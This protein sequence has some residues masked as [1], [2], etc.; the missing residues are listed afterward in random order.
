MTII[1]WHRF[2]VGRLTQTL[3]KYSVAQIYANYA[4]VYYTS[5][6]CV[7]AYLNPHTCAY[8]RMCMSPCLCIPISFF[9]GGIVGQTKDI[10]FLGMK[11]ASKRNLHVVKTS[12]RSTKLSYFEFSIT[13]QIYRQTTVYVQ[14]CSNVVYSGQ[15]A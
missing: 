10:I 11:K 4:Y 12:C 14:K 5:I 9:M 15:C 13:L 2:T 6:F 8:I 7:Y 1:L 3:V